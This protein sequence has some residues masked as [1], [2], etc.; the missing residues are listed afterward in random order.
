MVWID[1]RETSRGTQKGEVMGY[2]RRGVFGQVVH[3]HIRGDL[4]PSHEGKRFRKKLRLED[5]KADEETYFVPSFSIRRHLHRSEELLWDTNRKVLRQHLGRSFSITPA[6]EIS[7]KIVEQHRLI[8]NIREAGLHPEP[9]VVR[10]LAYSVRDGLTNLLSNAHSPLQ[11]SL[12]N[13][14]RFGYKGNS[15]AY[16]IDGWRGERAE[17]GLNDDEHYMDTNAVLLAER[18]LAVGAIALAFEDSELKVDGIAPS[19]HIT[20]ARA[21]ETVPDYRMREIR[22]ELGDIAI[23]EVYLGDPVIEAKLYRDVPP[24]RIP[25]R[26]AWESLAPIPEILAMPAMSIAESF[27][28]EYDRYETAVYA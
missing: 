11:V 13:F 5:F 27:E 2:G 24:E 28:D 3:P 8:K 6:N 10:D 7:L 26:Q 23:G 17:Y 22:G 9:E 12:G 20:I 15:V 21:K 18:Q 14:G 4:D 19:P 1:W 25:V 16:E